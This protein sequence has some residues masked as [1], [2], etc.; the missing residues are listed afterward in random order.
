MRLKLIR[1]AAVLANKTVSGLGLCE[2]RDASFVCRPKEPP[3]SRCGD[4]SRDFRE[5]A[6][7]GARGAQ[8]RRLIAFRVWD[9]VQAACGSAERVDPP[10]AAMLDPAPAF[11]LPVLRTFG[12]R[13]HGG[14]PWTRCPIGPIS[15]ICVSR[16]RTCSAFHAP[17]TQPRWRTLPASFR[18]PLVAR[19]QKSWRSACACMTLNLVWR[20]GR[21]R[22]GCLRSWES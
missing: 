14:L 18:P 8:W 19:K 13:T 11:V 2:D 17:V 20:A 5:I 10:A 9:A 6:W 21:R 4:T 16:R 15:S 12:H 7:K 3:L 22:L 1:R